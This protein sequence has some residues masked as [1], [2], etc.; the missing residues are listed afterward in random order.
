MKF[1]LIVAIDK[2]NGI[3]KNGVLPWHL[4]N[5]LAFFKETTT[6]TKTKKKNA[7]IMGRYTWE[8]IPEKYRPLPGRINIII[9]QNTT[10]TQNAFIFKNLE[11]AVEF[12]SGEAEE[13]FVIGGARLYQE[14]LKWVEMV[15]AIYIT[16]ITR[17]FD[18]DKFFPKEEYL[19]FF[20][21]KVVLEKHQEKG[22]NYQITRF[23]K[24]NSD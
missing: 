15:K 5:D 1:S 4:K 20:P 3:G 23:Y 13:V 7:V 9:S 14:C 16:E 17:S 11:E 12:A 22:I 6:K 8:S 18:C 2:C 21:K 10:L 24:D 19:Q